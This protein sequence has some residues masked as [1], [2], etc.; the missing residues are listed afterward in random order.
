M[1]LFLNFDNKKDK[2][3][4]AARFKIIYLRWLVFLEDIVLL[5]IKIKSEIKEFNLEKKEYYS[6]QLLLLVFD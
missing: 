1:F 2:L 5:K 4:I 6:K 3:N